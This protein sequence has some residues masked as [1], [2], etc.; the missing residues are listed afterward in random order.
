MTVKSTN[1]LKRSPFFYVGDK[2]KLIPQLKENFPTNINR[3][4]EPFC[5]GGSVFLN[6]NANSY[7]LNDIDSNMISLHKFLISFSDKTEEFW[8]EIEQ[9]IL[10]YGL[11]A[12]F[13]Q[14]TV[15]VELKKEYPKTYFAKYNK[16]AYYKMRKDY[17]DTH[18]ETLLYLL[19]IYGFNRFLRFNSNGEF[20]LPV[21]NVDFNGNVQKAL[22]EYFGYVQNKDISFYNCDF[23]EFVNTI[24]PTSEDLIY[25]DP[26]YL[27][28]FSEYNKLWNEDSEMRLIEFLDNLNCKG[29]KFA[30][31]NVLWHRQRYN[32]TFN[33]WAKKYNVV[34]IKSNY[35]SFHDNTEKNSVEVLVKN[36]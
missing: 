14:R 1:G 13:M 11:S 21:G 26:P 7:V 2:F 27:I 12:T 31:S 25:L 23:E 32:G 17:N 34:P 19:L 24:E 28:T 16:D 35:I 20:N 36:Y 22:D 10:K 5:G 30:V 3:F 4:I 9:L 15:P 6:I 8:N 18:N 29:V 33:D